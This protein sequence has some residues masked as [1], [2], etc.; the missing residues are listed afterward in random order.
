MQD[1]SAVRFRVHRDV[2]I[3]LLAVIFAG[4][5]WMG[6]EGIPISPLDGAVNAAAMPKALAAA[7]A[8]FSLLLIVRSLLVEW[9]FFRAAKSGS[10]K[11]GQARA[12]AED[13]EK[14]VTLR[15]HLRAAGVVLIGI[16]YLLILPHLG[17]L[18]SVTLLVF[19]MSIYLGAK[20]GLYTAAVAIV[21]AVVFY[22]LFVRLLHIP[23]PVGF[24][25]KLIG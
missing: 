10:A 19:G 17:Y 24:W 12:G 6:A 21:L 18:L 2:W 22:L 25:P 11:A 13:D 20:A 4:A 8:G 15:Q 7:L 23:L 5:Y 16:L 1:Q 14:S 9:M 3:G